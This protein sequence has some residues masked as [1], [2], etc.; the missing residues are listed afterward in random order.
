MSSAGG[1]V[2]PG[3]AASP[4]WG[5]QAAM[6]KCTHTKGKLGA[7]SDPNINIWYDGKKPEYTEKTYD[8]GETQDSSHNASDEDLSPEPCYYEASV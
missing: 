2:R 8:T 4:S 6:H 5:Q 3:W 1:G 7:S